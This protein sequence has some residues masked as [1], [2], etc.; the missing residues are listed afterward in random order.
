MSRPEPASRTLFQRFYPVPTRWADNDIYGHANNVAYYAWFDT[1][2]NQ[3]LI[4]EGG[5]QPGVDPVVGYVVASSCNYFA[6]VEYP[7]CLQLGLRVSRLGSKSVTWGIGVFVEGDTVSRATGQF[8]H[9]FVDQAS[10]QSAPIPE[11]IRLAIRTDFD[12]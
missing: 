9:A 2:V 6:P 11:R 4:E 10:N 1:V 12:V 8:T 7:Q 3:F 5:M